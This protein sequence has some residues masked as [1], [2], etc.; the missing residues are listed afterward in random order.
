[1]MKR[2]T[3]LF[4]GLLGFCNISSANELERIEK[5]LEKISSFLA[6]F[7]QK[8]FLKGHTRPLISFGSLQLKKNKQVEW[9]QKEPFKQRILLKNN[10]IQ[11]QVED[12]PIE[13]VTQ[14]NNPKVFG[15]LS[16]LVSVLSGDLQNIQNHFVVKLVKIEKG[17]WTID[18]K[19]KDEMLKELFSSILISGNKALES[20]QILERGG[21]KTQIVFSHRIV[22]GKSL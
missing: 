7:T 17:Q 11:M 1:M 13:E 8:K 9:I 14:E 10:S 22:N 16:I 6:E 15:L 4:F 5:E 2:R 20:V 21:D 19:V 12:D 18:L 3:I